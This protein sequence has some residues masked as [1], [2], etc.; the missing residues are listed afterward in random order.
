VDCRHFRS[1]EPCRPH[2][3]SG[4]RCG[5]CSAYDRLA[6]RILVVKL[7]SLGDVLRT[8]TCLAPLKARYPN[9]HITWVTRPASQ[10]LLVGN[11]SIDR[12]LT[13]DANY[14]ELLMAEQ[15]DLAIGPEADLVSASIMRL[16]RAAEVQGFVADGRGGVTCTNAAT[17]AWWRTGLDDTLKQSNRRTYGEWLYDVCGLSFPVAPPTLTI[18][19]S[20]R[21]RV[22]AFVATH[23]GPTR[24]R[25]CFNTGAS[26]RWREKRW[27]PSHY[28]ELARLLRAAHL[29]LDVILIGGA[30]ESKLNRDLLACDAGF[31]DAGTDGSVEDLG[32]FMAACDWVLTPDSL[33]YHVA[34]AVGV[35]T[36]CL[37]G[38]TSPWELDR[39]GQN[40]I[41]HADVPCIACYRAQ[42]P[43]D[44]TCMELL[45]P[46]SAFRHIERWRAERYA[47]GRVERVGE[48]SIE[49]P[50]PGRSWPLRASHRF[51]TRELPVL[52]DVPAPHQAAW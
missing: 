46:T 20:A 12:V 51:P 44:R 33:G 34:C 31:L 52:S 41:L 7:G 3:V 14:L 24:R 18:G 23:G 27:R 28:V 37:V 25:V 29:D 32:A 1:A 4:A 22:G 30:S 16:A 21:A 42:C 9:S 17:D 6:E 35:P 36:V 10:A 40:L 26:D 47:A 48:S 8:T 13:V 38:P 19:A 5:T 43:H 50:G 11:P 45:T 2:K 39:Y 49:S 15:F